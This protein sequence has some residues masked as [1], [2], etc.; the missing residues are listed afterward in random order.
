MLKQ[1]LLRLVLVAAGAVLALFA[2]EITL[3]LL[4]QRPPPGSGALDIPH[5]SQYHDPDFRQRRYDLR[6]RRADPGA[7]YRI[8]VVGDSFTWGS[9]VRE[10]DAYPDRMQARLAKRY[11]PD[12]FEVI[13]FSRPGWN[14]ARE[15]NAVR[16][17]KRSLR[18]D[19][20]VLGYCLNDADPVSQEALQRLM[21]GTEAREP[22][23]PV[24][25]V[26]HRHSRAYRL[27][28]DKL[29]NI[30][31]RR[32]LVRYYHAIYEHETGWRTTRASLTGFRDLA[33]ERRMP[34]LVVLFPILDSQLDWRYKYDDLHWR[35]RQTAEELGIDLL[36]LLPEYRGIDAR[37]LAAEPF[38]DGH[39]SE[40]AHRI[41]ADAILDRW[42]RR[43]VLP[44]PG[45]KG[46]GI[47]GQGSAK[48]PEP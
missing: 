13:N 26:L 21:S 43:G 30:R 2:L 33:A 45:D 24:S 32:A 29:E 18:P 17:W 34:F 37:R 10:E 23:G 39:P 38:V 6:R 40:L 22:A 48:I 9:R 35:L 36:D 25:R 12:R 41:A 46:T 19:A 31:R 20:L 5:T 11:G 16:R 44:P 3:R 7:P 47:R 14:T 27:L 1:I 15:L 42:V 28:Y 8:L 4:P